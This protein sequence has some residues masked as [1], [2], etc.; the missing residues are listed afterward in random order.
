MLNKVKIVIDYAAIILGVV[1]LAFLLIEPES[2]W[3]DVLTKIAAGVCL[4]YVIYAVYL[5]VDSPKF[6]WHLLNGAFLRKVIC[7]VILMPCLLTCVVTCDS[8]FPN[9]YVRC[10]K[11]LLSFGV[12]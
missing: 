1:T 4:C 9:G 5:F 6:D 2:S 3:L 10:S 11:E 8:L 12:L 7:L